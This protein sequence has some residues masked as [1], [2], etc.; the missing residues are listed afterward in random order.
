MTS[1]TY[2]L[3][4]VILF[5]HSAEI[6]SQK[7]IKLGLCVKLDE[8]YMKIQKFV[9]IATL[10]VPGLFKGFSK[11]PC[12]YIFGETIGVSSGKMYSRY[13][14]EGQKLEKCYFCLYLGRK[15][16]T[17]IEFYLISAWNVDCCYGNK[18]SAI[19]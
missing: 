2:V 13:V 8:I 14:N 9:A 12:N 5:K 19:F 18:I 16:D 7:Q 15:I 1:R 3:K 6:S 4:L 17:I 11:Y 10:S